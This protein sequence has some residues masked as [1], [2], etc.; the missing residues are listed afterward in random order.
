M[1]PEVCE[2][3]DVG[4]CCSTAYTWSFESTALWLH[5]RYAG[6]C[7]EICVLITQVDSSE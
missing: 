3:V 7:A 6:L 5:P 2:W 1:T 4:G